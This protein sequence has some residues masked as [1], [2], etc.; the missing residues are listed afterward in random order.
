MA[1]GI[2]RSM[3]PRLEIFSAGTKPESEINPHA[4]YVMKEIGI[5]ISSQSPT[6]VD[7]FIGA[8]FDYVIT[9]CDHA[10]ENCPVFTGEVKQNLHMGFED[11]NE[12][13]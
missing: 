12:I 5:D 11:P 2:L 10:R 1:E 4:V 9:V 6:H 8:S 7:R 3:N 13:Q